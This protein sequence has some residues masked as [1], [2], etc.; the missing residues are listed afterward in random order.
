MTMLDE[1]DALVGDD[2]RARFALRNLVIA[3]GDPLGDDDRGGCPA[4]VFDALAEKVRALGVDPY[5]RDLLSELAMGLSL[6]PLHF[7]DWAICFDDQDPECG[8]IR[9]VFPYGHDT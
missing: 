1:F 8:Q 3:R 7:V 6:C 2:E 9:A 4:D 5:A